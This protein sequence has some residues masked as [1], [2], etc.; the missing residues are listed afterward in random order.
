MKNKR[1]IGRLL[2]EY[3]LSKVKEIDPV[4][5]QNLL[6]ELKRMNEGFTN[7]L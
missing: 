5:V 3:V 1:D 6:E 7:M 4:I 2:E